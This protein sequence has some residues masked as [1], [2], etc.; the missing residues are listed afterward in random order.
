MQYLGIDWG[1]RRAAWCALDQGGELVEGMMSA[2]EEG[3]AR[4]VHRLG[5]DVRGLHRDDERR[6]V[7]PR[8]LD[9]IRRAA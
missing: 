9:A 8:P 6:R 3:L 4:L 1:I 2:D 7:G 5:P